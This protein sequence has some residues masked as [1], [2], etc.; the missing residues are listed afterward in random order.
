[1]TSRVR[2]WGQVAGN[3]NHDWRRSQPI[4]PQKGGSRYCIFVYA[5]TEYRGVCT[6][7]LLKHI[8][9][10]R[11]KNLAL[12][13]FAPGNIFGAKIYH[14]RAQLF[15]RGTH[16]MYTFVKIASLYYTLLLLLVYI[17][18]LSCISYRAGIFASLS[19]GHF[20]TAAFTVTIFVSFS[21]EGRSSR[22]IVKSSPQ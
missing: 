20:P 14:L 17:S 15:S 16:I 13:V 9:V 4:S 22:K 8:P 3:C 1:M 7:S 18:S 2:L 21:A 6:L 5:A 19:H 10:T 12:G 11:R